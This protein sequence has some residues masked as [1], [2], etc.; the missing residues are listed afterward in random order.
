MKKL[1]S[2]TNSRT[3]IQINLIQ[4]GLINFEVPLLFDLY[5]Q[6]FLITVSLISFRV[7]LF[8]YSYI[9]YE[10]FFWRFHALLVTFIL[11]IFLLII[12]PHAV[13]ILIGWDGLG[14]TS[15][16]L[17]IYFQRRK[18]FNAG[19]ITALRNRVGDVLILRALAFMASSYLWNFGLLAQRY[20]SVNIWLLALLVL[21]AC[22]KRAQLPF[23]AWL[24]A[25]IA[26]PTPV[27]RLVHSS[28]LVTAG[29][30]LV[31][32]LFYFSLQSWPAIILLI[33]GFLTIFMAGLTALAETDIKKIIALSTLRQLGVIILTLGG[34]GLEVGYYHM[35][36]HAFLKALLFITIGAIIHSVKDYQ[37][38][39]KRSINPKF[40]PLTL[41]FNLIA[42]FRLCGFPFTRGF[43]SK[44]LCIEF[45]SYS[46]TSL[47]LTFILFLATALTA[48]YTIRLIRLTLI[49]F[50]KLIR[51][52][53]TRDKDFFINY[54]IP[55]LFFLSLIGANW[56]KWLIFFSPMHFILP[57]WIKNLTLFSIVLLALVTLK[58]FPV[59]LSL[60]GRLKKTFFLWGL[61]FFSS[62]ILNKN[63]LILGK[64]AFFWGDL[65]FNSF[66]TLFISY[67]T[68][69]FFIIVNNFLRL[70][71]LFQGLGLAFLLIW[72]IF[73]YLY[74]INFFIFFSFKN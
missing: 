27:S 56:I 43:Y 58:I 20:L 30:Y 70:R 5:S 46:T 7:I 31:F 57:L 51:I 32:R 11:R 53:W 25:A 72:R 13:S 1:I 18:S 41:A 62:Q 26:A 8:S 52:S 40:F 67:P 15:Y 29:V 64:Q 42:N 48:I 60:V 35:V 44:D 71:Q 45:F 61:P 34:G 28:T 36:S 10:K 66:R 47:P 21:A 69:P 2:K 9:F 4:T 33:I 12:R 39:R 68:S 3:Y 49:P 55:L 6:I 16:L 37:D 17:V 24:P 63:G 14:V 65:K 19:I 38:I 54:S 73:L 50:N 74:I 22:T 23:S 59:R